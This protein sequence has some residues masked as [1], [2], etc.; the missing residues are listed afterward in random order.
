MRVDFKW[1]TVEIPNHSYLAPDQSQQTYQNCIEKARENPLE[2][3]SCRTGLKV[4]ETGFI[5]FY[6]CQLI[7]EETRILMLNKS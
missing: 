7:T 6:K 1:P 3:N 5:L 4:I 2:A